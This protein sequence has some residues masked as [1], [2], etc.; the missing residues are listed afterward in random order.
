MSEGRFPWRT[1]LFLSL[2][3][4]LLVIGAA[5][6]AFGAGVRVQRETSRAVVERMPGPRAFM[7]ALPPATREK[8][9]RE[10]ERSWEETRE[11]RGAA[12]QARRDAFMAAEQE[13]YDAERVR[14]AF[15]QLRSAD[16]AAIAVF[17]NNIAEAFGALA[18]EERRE[19]L[20]ALRR[21]SPAA[22]PGVAPSGAE[23]AQTP[24]ERFRE[25]MRERRR[26]RRE[27]QP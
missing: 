16:Q 8:M 3:F 4:N 19:A 6:G 26:A 20:A 1:L 2:A 27:Q 25:K 14:A 11:A 23:D 13:P 22:R 15:A 9:R 5:V 18:P 21:A 10:L 17:H 12:L 24:R 7:A